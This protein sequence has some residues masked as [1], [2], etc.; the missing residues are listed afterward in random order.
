MRHSIIATAAVASVAGSAMATVTGNKVFGDSYVVQDGSTKYSVLDVYVKSNSA[1]DI[2]ASVYGISTFKASW[3]QAQSRSFKHAGNSAWNPNYTDAAGAAWDSFVTTGLRTQSNDGYGGTSIGLTA[4][5]G[6]SNFNSANAIKVTGATTGNGP[7][8][9]PAAGANPTTNPYCRFGAYN[10]DT[11]AINVAKNTSNGLNG[12]AF[13]QSLDNMFMIG[14]FAIDITSDSESTVL[15][16][17]FKFCMTVVSDGTQKA[18]STDTNFRVNSQTLQFA[19]ANVPSPGSAAL[20]ALAGMVSRR[21][22]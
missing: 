4:D 1:N 20:V 7:G 3:V 6:F 13:G 9:Y 12:F 10:G 15:T 5:P 19:M 14:R 21:R 22:K 11:S 8:W 18:G 16:M 2:F 17:S